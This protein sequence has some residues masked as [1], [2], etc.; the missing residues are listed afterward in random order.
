MNVSMLEKEVLDARQR[1]NQTFGRMKVC[2][3]K[4][5]QSAIVGVSLLGLAQRRIQTETGTARQTAIRKFQR[6]RSA[7]NNIFNQI[8]SERNQRRQNHEQSQNANHAQA[9]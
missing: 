7:L 4:L 6:I 9:G 2:D 3:L 1:F 5:R 8:E